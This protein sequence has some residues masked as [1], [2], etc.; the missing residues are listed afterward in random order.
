MRVCQ[1]SDLNIGKL[2]DG[3]MKTERK[4]LN[5]VR[6]DL[7]SRRDYGNEIELSDIETAVVYHIK[8]LGI[9]FREIDQKAIIGQLETEF[10]EPHA[11]DDE[12]DRSDILILSDN[13]GGTWL[14]ATR[15]ANRKYWQRY[16]NWLARKETPWSAKS[17]EYLDKSTDAIL[18]QMGDPRDKEWNIRG[19]V[20]GDVQSG[21]TANYNGLICK[22][23]DAGYKI[24]IVLAGIHSDLRKQTQERLEEGFLG[25]NTLCPDR[26]IGVCENLAESSTEAALCANSFTTSDNGGD[27]SLP[28]MK[29]HFGTKT[30]T[31]LPSLFVIK[32]HSSILG[33]MLTWIKTH[34]SDLEDLPLLLVDDEADNASVN[35][36]KGEEVSAINKNIRGILNLFKKNAYVGYTATPFANVLINPEEDDQEIGKDIYPSDFIINLRA[37]INYFGPRRLFGPQEAPKMALPLIRHIEDRDDWTDGTK[38]NAISIEEMEEVGL[39]T[40]LE[41]AILEFFLVCGVRSLRREQREHTSML[42]HADVGVKIQQHIKGLVDDFVSNYIINKLNARNNKRFRNRLEKIYNDRLTGFRATSR[43]LQAI[44]KDGSIIIDANMPTFLQVWKM[45]PT[46]AESMAVKIL[47]SQ[48]GDMLDYKG[49]LQETGSGL[50][51]IVIG[52][53]TLSRGLT[54][55]GLA[56]SYFLRYAGYYDTL[57]QMARWF[58]YRDGY[59]DLCRIYIPED[60]EDRY[61]WIANALDE[62]RS[63]FE[64]AARNGISP[65]KYGFYIRKHPI[66][67]ITSKIISKT[68]NR[69]ITLSYGG[70][71]EQT[72]AFPRKKSS[73]EENYRTM[74]RLINRMGTPLTGNRIKGDFPT[75]RSWAGYLWKNIDWSLITEFLKNYKYP[76]GLRRFHP[77]YIKSYIERMATEHEE[78]TNW[79]VALLGRRRGADNWLCEI[80]DSIRINCIQRTGMEREGE[81]NIRSLI[82][83]EDEYID[84]SS[85][86]W[87]KALRISRAL[88]NDGRLQA[89]REPKEPVGSVIRQIRGGRPKNG[90]LLLYLLDILNNENESVQ[91]QCPFAAFAISFPTSENSAYGKYMVDQAYMEQHA[92]GRGV[93]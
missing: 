44:I 2:Q 45:L 31:S 7:N 87:K 13:T 68:P 66:I 34:K 32:K 50:N 51:V 55:E 35:I 81:Y 15:K 26:K 41:D 92:S 84:L 14:T 5:L 57:L 65:Q 28:Y 37:P 56:V 18:G 8:N 61:R 11:D 33:N 63:E 20:V 9:D 77:G 16:S 46:V 88:Y 24:I 67:E 47:N 74:S 52:G 89:K 1:D 23:A 70:F 39:L 86:E 3:A 21:K 83:P 29:A 17:L 38:Q 93:D 60:I 79:T 58:G 69:S 91:D 27:F 12:V 42:I 40:S 49:H 90:L 6:K 73:I 10:L 64:M 48:S 80:S 19:M 4:I 43:N 71:L 25:Y 76:D 22:A 30:D 85:R 62:L 75:R 72:L 78:L 36:G 82:S 53:N 54:L 59:L